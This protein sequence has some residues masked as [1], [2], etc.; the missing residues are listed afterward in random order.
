M[1]SPFEIS[2]LE[3][4]RGPL[5]NLPSN[6]RAPPTATERGGVLNVVGGWVCVRQDG[7]ERCVILDFGLPG[8]LI[9]LDA[10]PNGAHRSIAT[11]TDASLCPI[12]R[13]HL[14]SLRRAHSQFDTRLFD[15]V[16]AASAR[17][18]RRLAAIAW[19]T[20]KERVASL[21][22][23][24]AERARPGRGL[25][26][27]EA[28]PLPLTQ[29]HIAEATGQTTIHVNRMLRELREDGVCRFDRGNLI[30]D[31]LRAMSDLAG[32][33]PAARAA[34]AELPAGG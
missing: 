27:G 24:L 18:T 2:Q 21:L 6:V 26:E 16:T 28:V 4:A 9:E 10:L 30:I 17:R 12:S 23:E 11:L 14:Q 31:D 22:L 1:A 3:W 25:R 7:P 34:E 33:R 8:E 29:R 15:L 20:A 19:R 5:L 32:F 13:E